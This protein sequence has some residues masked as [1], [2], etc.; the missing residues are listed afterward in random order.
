MAVLLSNMEGDVPSI[1][2]YSGGAGIIHL[3]DPMGKKHK[4]IVFGLSYV[5]GWQLIT[6]KNEK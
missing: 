4:I 5:T 1:P 6:N 2:Y 3:V